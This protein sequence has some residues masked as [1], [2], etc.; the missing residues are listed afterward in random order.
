MTKSFKK[1]FD[2]LPIEEQLEARRK[3]DE[4]IWDIKKRQAEGF[5]RK[6]LKDDFPGV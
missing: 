2:S 5:N 4:L 3:R 1:L 6:I